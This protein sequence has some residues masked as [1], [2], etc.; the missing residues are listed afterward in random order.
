MKIKWLPIFIMILPL[1]LYAAS[2]DHSYKLWGQVLGTHITEQAYASTIDYKSIKASP[3]Q[4]NQYL[5]EIEGLT[6]ESYLA[7]SKDQQLAFMINAYNALTIKLII[8]NYPLKSIRDIGSIITGPWKQKFFKLFGEKANLD[9]IEHEII[10]KKF[11]EPRI[12]FALVCASIGC[13]ALSSKAYT[14]EKLDQ[15]LEDGA[16]KFISDQTRNRYI[17]NKKRLE[18]SSIFKWYGDDF[19]NKYGSYLNF[20]VDRMTENLELRKTLLSD[21]TTI[22]YLAYNWNLNET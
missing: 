10:R 7:F 2:F 14:A 21:K 3:G 8:D 1:K 16:K 13:P 11:D 18:L 9:H 20:V 12:H 17:K 4:L 5:K 22:K 6:E 19:K 15:Q